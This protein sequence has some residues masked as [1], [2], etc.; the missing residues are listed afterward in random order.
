[1]HE[2]GRV[3]PDGRGLDAYEVAPFSVRQVRDRIA[4]PFAGIPHHGLWR[5]RFADDDRAVQRIVAQAQRSVGRVDAVNH[6]PVEGES[7]I[8][9]IAFGESG[10]RGVEI[11]RAGQPQHARLRHVAHTQIGVQR[12]LVLQRALA[13][14]GH[15][16]RG[17]KPFADLDV[18]GRPEPRAGAGD[19][20]RHRGAV[21]LVRVERIADMAVGQGHPVDVPE[22]GTGEPVLGALRG[23]RAVVVAAV[24]PWEDDRDAGAQRDAGREGQGFRLPE[25]GRLPGRGP[26]DQ[27]GPV[28]A[29]RGRSVAVDDIAYN[30][31]NVHAC[32]VYGNIRAPPCMRGAG[33]ASAARQRRVRGRR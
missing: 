2:A 1:M 6:G 15:R 33:G 25:H 24:E 3:V 30:T 32:Q 14:V 17:R 28:V 23:H 27:M 21:E 19:D 12:G 10:P 16:Q 11:A 20:L 26:A 4:G 18:V 29:D 8:R 13:G 22:A 5:T 7:V 31:C 9:L